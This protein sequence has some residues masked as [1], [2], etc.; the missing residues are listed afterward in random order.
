MRATEATSPQTCPCGSAAPAKSDSSHAPRGP[1]ALVDREECVDRL[2]SRERAAA[3]IGR[4]HEAEEAGD[5]DVALL[6]RQEQEAARDLRVGGMDRRGEVR[7]PAAAVLV[8]GAEDGVAM[9]LLVGRLRVPEVVAGRVGGD[10]HRAVDALRVAPGVDHRRARA[11]T[12]ADQ[13]DRSVAESLACELEVFDALG[14][15]VPGEID[16]VGLEP[17]G[18]GTVGGGV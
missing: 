18:A 10:H 5:A 4:V 12:L 3:V 13:V 8:L 7:C 11:G 6:D 9:D 15:R 17:L 2:R 1:V 16:A 14:Q